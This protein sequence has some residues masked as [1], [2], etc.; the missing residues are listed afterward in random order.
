[1]YMHL[2]SISK[3]NPVIFKMNADIYVI[4]YTKLINTKLIAKGT[5]HFQWPSKESK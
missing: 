3:W 4:N 5:K 2:K 1:M